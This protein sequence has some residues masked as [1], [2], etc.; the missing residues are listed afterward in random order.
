[1]C[2]GLHPSTALLSGACSLLCPAEHPALI[3]HPFPATPW[4]HIP[5]APEASKSNPALAVS[6]LLLISFWKPTAIRPLPSPCHGNSSCE[7]A[8]LEFQT[9]LIGPSHHSCCREASSPHVLRLLFPGPSPFCPSRTSEHFP[10][11]WS[12]LSSLL[13]P[14]ILHW[15]S[16]VCVFSS[17]PG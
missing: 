5:L 11:L 8:L 17:W 16:P 13:T 14:A 4:P 10:E 12:Q 3:L 15:A 7:V 9:R 6:L 2:S 1:M